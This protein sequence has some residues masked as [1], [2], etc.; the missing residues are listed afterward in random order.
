MSETTFSISQMVI[1][2]ASRESFLPLSLPACAPLRRRGMLLAGYSE[3]VPPYEIVRPRSQWHSLNITLRGGAEFK[4]PG[5]EAI[6]EPGVVWFVPAGVACRY[7]I[8][9]GGFWHTLWFH[10]RDIDRWRWGLD[11]GPHRRPMPV[12]TQLVSAVE[13]L[14]AESVGVEPESAEAAHAYA[15]L[16]GIYVDRL[17][18]PEPQTSP[19]QAELRER[20][21][22]VWYEVDAEL[23]RRWTL[24]ELAGRLQISE[25]SL[26]R[27]VGRLYGTTP[28]ARVAELRMRRAKELLSNSTNSLEEI[29]QSVGYETVF[30]FSKAFKR[31]T[32]MSPS[33]FREASRAADRT[34]STRIGNTKAHHDKSALPASRQS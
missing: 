13:A 22:A 25:S 14:L 8:P 6:L 5:A 28:L 20:L 26:Q 9:D 30:A 10:L 27:L 2:P 33:A 4:S 1:S 16:I 19:E 23:H 24:A 29:S 7:S 12:P 18:G 11:K 17:L 31:W 21:Q 34:G 32:G 15:E 3:L